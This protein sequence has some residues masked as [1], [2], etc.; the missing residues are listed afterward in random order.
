MS[1]L[2]ES[3]ERRV[4][5]EQIQRNGDRAARGFASL[6][7]SEGDSVAMLLRNDV[8]MFEAMA[9]A[10]VLGAY[11]VPINWHSTGEE[12]GYV[13]RDC[14]ARV[15]VV[16]ADLLAKVQDEL[17][18]AMTVLVAQ[19]PPEIADAYGIARERCA[20]AAGA[21]DWD[22]WLSRFAPWDA[23][24]AA[25]RGSMISRS[26]YASVTDPRSYL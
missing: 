1:Y 13:I 5:I 16:H 7:V 25:S 18:G 9:A 17:P 20:P 10:N 4:P 22:D 2:V 11:A 6:G 26:P 8:C 15:L 14:G 23:P 24:P 21:L 19:T 3:G 12:S